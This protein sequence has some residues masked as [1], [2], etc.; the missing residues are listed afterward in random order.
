MVEIGISSGMGERPIELPAPCLF[1]DGGK[2]EPGIWLNVHADQDRQEKAEWLGRASDDRR[3][4]HA[5]RLPPLAIGAESISGPSTRR[6]EV[7][8]PV[9]LALVSQ[10]QLET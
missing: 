1:D 4:V 8:L 7:E 5:E 2:S 9:A 6:R 10:K 3:R